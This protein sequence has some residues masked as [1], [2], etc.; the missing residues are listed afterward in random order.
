MQNNPTFPAAPPEVKAAAGKPRTLG[1][2]AVWIVLVVGLLVV[3]DILVARAGHVWTSVIVGLLVCV[4]L[5][6][7]VTTRVPHEVPAPAKDASASEKPKQ[8]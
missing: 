1:G 4:F 2:V 6:F 3:A 8:V 7:L 5:A